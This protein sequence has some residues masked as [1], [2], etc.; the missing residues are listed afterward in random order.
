MPF[1]TA[2]LCD[3]HEDETAV[4]APGLRSFGGRDR[5]CGPARTLA[6]FEDN[7]LIREALE[8]PG[9]GHVLVVDAGAS[10]RCAV[11]GGNLGELAADNGW[12]GIV[13][14]GCV[15]DREELARA[16]TGVVALGLNPRRS[17]KRGHGA[18]GTVIEV[19]GVAVAPGAW[20][21]VD[22]DGVV[23]APRDIR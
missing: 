4:V 22:A 18:A 9:E 12:S 2:D 16:D 6:V 7:T 5:F 21:Y 11:V 14:W 17:V 10:M 13:V 20:V 15:R 19:G 1:A 8:G 23:V 3:A